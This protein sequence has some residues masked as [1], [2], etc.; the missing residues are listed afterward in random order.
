MGR[1]GVV[2]L[3]LWV[4]SLVFGWL[5]QAP[6]LLL[7]PPI[8]LFV[9]R[10]LVLRSQTARMASMGADVESREFFATMLLPTLGFAVWN[11]AICAATFGLGWLARSVID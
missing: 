9:E 1:T 2:I 7:A 11:G 10:L 8:I 3:V 5:H 6:L 4:A